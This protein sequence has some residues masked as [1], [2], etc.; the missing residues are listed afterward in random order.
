MSEY[1]EVEYKGMVARRYPNGDIRNERGQVLKLADNSPLLN[2]HAITSE[3][4]H[5]KHLQRK[6][7]ILRAIETG[8]MRVTDAPNPYEAISRIV[9]KRAEVALND[10]GRAGNDASKIVLMA[11]DALQDRRQETTQVQRHEYSIDPE[12][13]RI[14]EAMAQARRDNTDVIEIEIEE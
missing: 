8:V 9:E 3:N 13:M 2:E 7:K 1:T 4:A 12:T 14:V 6:E 5:E 11:L 10:S